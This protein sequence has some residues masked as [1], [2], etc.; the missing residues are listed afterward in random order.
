[1]ASIVAFQ[2]VDPGSIP[3]HRKI[4]VKNIF[5]Y[6]NN[7]RNKDFQRN[8]NFKL[9][10]LYMKYLNSPRLIGRCPFPPVNLCLRAC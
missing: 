10:L 4:F 9:M 7:Q 1:M 3:G 5:Y 2:A 6:R 8:K